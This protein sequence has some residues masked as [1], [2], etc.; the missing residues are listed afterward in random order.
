MKNALI[1]AHITLHWL[2]T[3]VFKRRCVTYRRDKLLKGRTTTTTKGSKI[4]DPHTSSRFNISG[5]ISE[6]QP[7]HFKVRMKL[8]WLYVLKEINLNFLMYFNWNVRTSMTYAVDQR[9]FRRTH[10]KTCSG[11]SGGTGTN[12]H[13]KC[14]RFISNVYNKPNRLKIGRKW[15]KLLLFKSACTIKTQYYEWASELP[16]VRWPPNA[17]RAKHLAFIIH[18]FTTILSAKI[19]LNLPQCPRCAPSLSFYV[20][21][22]PAVFVPLAVFA[23]QTFAQEHKDAG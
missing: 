1:H 2:E 14:H 17:V 21:A 12:G 13:P 5:S 19:K 15:S 6:K 9:D 4:I 11:V 7:L 3:K 20:M 10:L 18:I 8:Q 22:L 16:V 23:R